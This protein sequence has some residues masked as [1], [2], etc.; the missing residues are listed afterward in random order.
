MTRPS[1]S[2]FPFDTT[3]SESDPAPGVVRIADRSLQPTAVFDSYWRFA[4]ARHGI[5]LARLGHSPRPWT[6]DEILLSYRFTNVFR[7]SD[8]VSQYLIANIV[9]GADAPAQPAD[10]VFRTLLF[11]IFNREDTWEHLETRVGPVSWATFDFDRYRTALDEA[12]RNGP[13]YSAAYLMPPPR[14]GEDRKHANHLRLL[15]M[16]MRDGLVDHVLSA[17]SLRG[18]YESLVAYPGLGPFLAFQYAIDLNYSDVVAFDENDHV[19]AG[20][21]A[22]DGIRK[23]FGRDALGIE[24]DVIRYMV[25]TQEMHFNRLGLAFPGLFGRPLHLIDAQNLFCETDKYSRVRHPEIEG[26]SGRSRIKQK[27]RHRGPLPLP[28]FPRRWCLEPFDSDVHGSADVVDGS[29]VKIHE[30]SA[31]AVGAQRTPGRVAGKDR[32]LP[33]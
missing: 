18:L 21:G 19:V 11:K 13:I 3:D 9:R 6:D 1:H 29:L 10:V 2:L 15:E 26:I 12:A 8:R 22:K 16:M 30:N 14:L 25:D 5:Y 4:S 31:S 32:P 24:A 17:R 23:C 28:V 20:P 7:A 33:L 27:Y